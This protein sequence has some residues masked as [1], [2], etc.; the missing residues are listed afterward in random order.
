MKVRSI[1]NARFSP[2]GDQLLFVARTALLSGE[3]GT[4]LNQ[5]YVAR[6]DGS[7]QRALTP[8]EYSVTGAEWSPD[9]EWIAVVSDF[10]ESHGAT[11]GLIPSAGG[12]PRKLDPGLAGVRNVRWSPDGRKIAFTMPVP[13][14]PEQ[15]AAQRHPERPQVVDANVRKIQ[16]WVIDVGRDGAPRGAA[17]AVTPEAVDVWTRGEFETAFAYGNPF[18]W[19]PD[20]SRLAFSHGDGWVDQWPSMSLSV[21]DVV[22]GRTQTVVRSG[23]FAPSFSPDGRRI[24]YL[25]GA[26]PYAAF[27]NLDV[28]VVDT[29]GGVP[30]KP[31]STFDRRPTLIGWGA[32]GTAVLVTEA[33]KSLTRLLAL[34]VTGDG[35]RDLD[36]GDAVLSG[37]ALDR[38]RTMIAFALERLSQPPEVHISRLD[39]F[40]PVQVSHANSSL[41]THPLPRTELV[42][43]T[44][45]DGAVVEG[46]LTYPVPYEAGRRYPLVVAVHTGGRGFQQTF[47]ATSFG[48]DYYPVTELALRGFA[49]FR[50]NARGGVLQ[51]YGP[52]YAVPWFKVKDKAEHDVMTGADRVIQ[53]GVADAS[54]LGISGFSNG[55]L[56]T[57]WIIT[58]TARFKA[59]IIRAGFPDLIADAA[60]EAA[61]AFHM[62][63]APWQNLRHTWSTRRCS[64]SARSRRRRSFCTVSVMRQW[65][66]ARGWAFTAY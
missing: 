56:V 26:G 39:R 14:T 15:L 53:M 16:L 25:G 7:G 37:F 9:G 30:R 60:G 66:S 61:K 27:H 51:G 62:D 11:I 40:H 18:D 19:S 63:A 13:A 64:A 42:Q 43:W 38:S 5:V 32:D 29:D 1:A 20:G 3:R 28:F 35:G 24:A 52:A 36:A 47:V 17:R 8:N 22:S 49:V 2:N 4:H 57:S 10:G 6:A 31:A 34:P 45:A 46:L 21:V 48:V 33:R 55:G 54:R 41:P 12:A 59:A 58:Q 50:C 65:R 44:S 23:A